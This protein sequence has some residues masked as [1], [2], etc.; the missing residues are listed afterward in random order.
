MAEK[1]YYGVYQGIVTNITDPEKRGRIKIKCPEVLGGEVESA[2]CD[3]IVTVAFDNGG[4]FC[5]PS[6]KEAVWV[7]FI[8]G[9]VNRPAYLGGWWQKEMTPLGK[10]YSK[11]D[12]V[13]IIN[14]A[15]CTILMQDDKIDINVGDGTCDLRIE[16]GVVTV[17][18]NLKVDGSITA[19]SVVA[20]GVS[21]TT[22]THGGVYS[23]SSNTSKPN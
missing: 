22:H 12:K 21:L 23:G 4:D 2:W 15:D 10:T 14:Y 9:D 18:G 13:R 17:K 16:D 5:I 3:P 20:D 11:I 8:S 7:L 19:K 1:K 6:K